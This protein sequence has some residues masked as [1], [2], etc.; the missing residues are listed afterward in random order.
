[1]LLNIEDVLVTSILN[2]CIHILYLQKDKRSRLAL[3][4]KDLDFPQA[5]EGLRLCST[6]ISSEGQNAVPSSTDLGEQELG[7]K[8]L[9]LTELHG[10]FGHKYVCMC[11]LVY[12]QCVVFQCYCDAI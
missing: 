4:L 9:L 7:K 6:G 2:K 10:K 1:M 3:H 12:H 8:A 11:N 5:L